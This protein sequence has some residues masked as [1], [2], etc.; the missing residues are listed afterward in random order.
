[1]I[2]RELDQLV[3]FSWWVF[4]GRDVMV[5]YWRRYRSL[6]ESTEAVLQA[7][8]TAS[9]AATPSMAALVKA[10]LTAICDL[11]WMLLS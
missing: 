5:G 3:S 10:V 2:S 9:S 4:R 7:R 8:S 11:G 1:M 6:L